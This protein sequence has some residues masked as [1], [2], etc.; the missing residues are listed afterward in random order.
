MDYELAL[1]WG[2]DLI[3]LMTDCR[4]QGSSDTGCHWSRIYS[5][6]IKTPKEHFQGAE[7]YKMCWYCFPLLEL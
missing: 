2:L 5:H 4:A 6:F 1:L 3:R 7:L